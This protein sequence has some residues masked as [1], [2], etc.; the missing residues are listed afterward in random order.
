MNLQDTLFSLETFFDLEPDSLLPFANEDAIGGFDPDENKRQW[1]VGSIFG[2]EGQVL[3]AL[4][5]ALK[6]QHVLEIGG[7]TGC[8]GSHIA[9][10]LRAN[11]SGTL[12]SLDRG[13]TPQILVDVKDLVEIRNDDAINYLAML[14]DGSL[15][16]I[17]EDADHS[18]QLCAAV[19]ELAKS[20]LA[21]GGLLI[22]HDAAH[23]AVG[24]DVVRG[25]DR[26]GLAHRVYLT[27]PSDCG[28]LVWRKEPL[29]PIVDGWFSTDGEHWV[30][31]ARPGESI[32]SD[33][34]ANLTGQYI[35]NDLEDGVEIVA[36][37]RGL[38]D[39][40]VLQ[41]QEDYPP[42]PDTSP[43]ATAEVN[44]AG[45]TVL[46]VDTDEAARV[47]EELAAQ[48][49]YVRDIST[50]KAVPG[51]GAGLRHL[52]DAIEQEDDP[53]PA[54]KKPGRKPKKAAK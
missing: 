39:E 17:W 40:P 30:N 53:P 13:N 52:L 11:D 32:E 51:S 10:A 35:V 41:A 7:G 12:V 38:L 9:R 50:I 3:Y 22:A 42:E 4:V 2:V 43:L 48:D 6:P 8:S 37:A 26:A 47:G 21:P 1:T 34:H 29:E 28:M 14:P 36:Q 31:P 49:E 27:E 20:K 45:E 16:M 46:T 23:F 44:A 5:R 25:Y 18:E 33:P 24:G 15:D 54:K 19:G